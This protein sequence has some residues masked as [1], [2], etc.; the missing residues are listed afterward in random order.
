M[1]PNIHI[2]ENQWGW[3]A[4]TPLKFIHHGREHTA[5]RYMSPAGWREEAYY[6][7]TEQGVKEELKRFGN[8]YIPVINI[9]DRYAAESRVMDEMLFDDTYKYSPFEDSMEYHESFA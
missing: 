1:N 2:N 9:N 5:H 8:G 4:S 3:Y 6:Y 7:K